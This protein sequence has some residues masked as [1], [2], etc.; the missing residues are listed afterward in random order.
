MGAAADLFVRI[1]DA[2][3]VFGGNAGA[4]VDD[5]EHRDLP[6]IGHPQGD[7]AT[8]GK[9]DG[10]ADQVKQCLPQP[11]RIGAHNLRQ[12]AHGFQLEFQPF[13]FGRRA[14]HPAQLVKEFG[15]VHRLVPHAQHTAFQLRDVQQ[16][17][18]QASDVFAAAADH[19]GSLLR[20]DVGLLLD[21]L[22][23]A[24]NGVERGADFMADRGQVALLDQVGRFRRFLGPQSRFHAGR[25]DFQ[26]ID[27]SAQQ[28]E[29]G[30]AAQHD[31]QQYGQCHP[32]EWS[33]IIDRA[34]FGR[35]HRRLD[36]SGQQDQPQGYVGGDIM[37]AG[38]VLRGVRPLGGCDGRQWRG[39]R[40]GHRAMSSRRRCGNGPGH[41]QRS[42]AR[43]QCNLAGG[44]FPSS[45]GFLIFPSD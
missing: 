21:Q 17:F 23:I 22:G 7:A 44:V 25:Q 4:G 6:A 41:P 38:R 5:V 2:L 37:G 40:C 32:M 36:G 3:L 29:A 27:P 1:E 18:G 20:I 13:C 26:L 31:H 14:H 19:P 33:A 30:E 24:V 45:I 11:A 15:Q 42:T 12:A 34:G 35:Q 9:L 10:V 43:A 8:F 39:C 28:R 16:P